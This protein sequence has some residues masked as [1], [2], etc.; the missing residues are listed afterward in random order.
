[1]ITKNTVD[2]CSDNFSIAFINISCLK[3]KITL[4][5]MPENEPQSVYNLP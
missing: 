4:T 3:F 2:N 5:L 1:M